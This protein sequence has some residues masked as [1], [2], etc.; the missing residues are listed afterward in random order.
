MKNRLMALFMAAVLSL[1][2][3]A[4]TIPTAAVGSEEPTELIEVG[5]DLIAKF[6]P[7]SDAKKVNVEDGNG[8]LHIYDRYHN[9]SNP[10]V[11]GNPRIEPYSMNLV[12]ALGFSLDKGYQFIKPYV[13]YITMKVRMANEWADQS[14]VS[15]AFPNDAATMYFKMS[16]GGAFTVFDLWADKL[17][18]V[19]YAGVNGNNWDGNRDIP[20]AEFVGDRSAVQIKDAVTL[21]GERLSDKIAREKSRLPASTYASYKTYSTGVSVAIGTDWTTLTYVVSPRLNWIIGDSGKTFYTYFTSEAGAYRNIPFDIDDFEMYYYNGDTKVSLASFDFD[22]IDNPT[23]IFYEQPSDRYGKFFTVNGRDGAGYNR[24]FKIS[25]IKEYDYLE[26]AAP[27]VGGKREAI[28]GGTINYSFPENTKLD[29][30]IYELT[31]EARLNFYDGYI[32]DTDAATNYKPIL[33]S[34]FIDGEDNTARLEIKDNYDNSWGINEITS[35]WGEVSYNFIVPKGVDFTLS[36]VNAV[37][38][39]DTASVNK[40]FNIRNVKIVKTESLFYDSE[41]EKSEADV[42]YT[43]EDD[44]F[45]ISKG[46]SDATLEMVYP[47]SYVEGN[48]YLTISGRTNERDGF[49]LDLRDV[50]SNS[51]ENDYRFSFKVRASNDLSNLKIYATDTFGYDPSWTMVKLSAGM[52]NGKY[53]TAAPAIFQPNGQT[54][55]YYRHRLG[56]SGCYWWYFSNAEW[57]TVDVPFNDLIL[58]IDGEI[59]RHNVIHFGGSDTAYNAVN[60]D[61]DDI[62]VYSDSKGEIWKQDFQGAKTGELSNSLNEKFLP[63]KETWLSD[64]FR[65]EAV[66]LSIG[67]DAQYFTA[68]NVKEL[69][70]TAPTNSLSIKP[71]RYTIH[72]DFSYP[73]F[74][75][76]RITVD[77]GSARQRN[78]IKENYNKFDVTAVVETGI[79]SLKLKP[80]TVGNTWTE[81]EFIFDAEEA[82]TIKSISFIFKDASGAE[83]TTVC[84]RNIYIDGNY[85]EGPGLPYTGITMLLLLRKKAIGVAEQIKAEENA[86]RAL[87]NREVVYPIADSTFGV[88]SNG[89]SSRLKTEYPGSFEEG[90]KYMRVSGRYN[91]RDG[92]IIDLRRAVLDVSEAEYRL[93]FKI[94]SVAEISNIWLDNPTGPFLQKDSIRLGEGM[95]DGVYSYASPTIFGRNTIT[96]AGFDSWINGWYMNNTEWTTVDVSFAE[97][98]NQNVIQIGGG[99]YGCN[100]SDFDIDDVKVYVKGEEPIYFEDFENAVSGELSTNLSYFYVP[101]KNGNL[102]DAYRPYGVTL[103]VEED[104]TYFASSGA[105]ELKYSVAEKEVSL[106]AGEYTLHAEFSYPYFDGKVIEIAEAADS[107]KQSY[108]KS[109]ANTFDVT[110]VIETDNGTLTFD[111][112][113]VRNSWVDCE[114]SFKVENDTKV[115]TVSFKLTPAGEAKT[116]AVSFR[117]VYIDGNLAK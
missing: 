113:A 6:K 36:D 7:T 47:T 81:C 46:S 96:S 29:A 25:N 4:A 77:V 44:A 51:K 98:K 116:T 38:I 59:T 43:I 26:V 111:K 86:D 82:T 88:I 95:Y 72:A 58:N 61:V 65:K 5:T 16:T 104:R 60:F 84:Y 90:N 67:E 23:H 48:K 55:S 92:I 99:A 24:H 62:T 70:Y 54:V 89:V 78:Y 85:P 19:T 79:G 80:R 76:D 8:Y 69:K 40:A 53:A 35:E 100:T 42:V 71:G 50:V 91:N 93:S 41:F 66:T 115:K 32:D 17:G 1:S 27:V 68:K 30:G 97:L 87:S 108:F 34:Q 28:S 103:E 106:A 3:F 10:D 13:Y 75:G 94:R 101:F 12:T 2:T 105:S 112:Y 21:G 20:L 39:D 33:H 22:D 102:T 110:A 56:S 31:A 74:D 114:F 14:E 83:Y 63:F 73:Y 49:I 45:A 64:A 15:N 11:R 107:K 9:Y 117:D 109:N 57:H 18:T 37:F 52:Y